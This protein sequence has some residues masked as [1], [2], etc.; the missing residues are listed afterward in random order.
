MEEKMGM[1]WVN[2]GQASA[3]KHFEMVVIMDK[4]SLAEM[5]HTGDDIIGDRA[6]VCTC[7]H[8][9]THRA[10]GSGSREERGMDLTVWIKNVSAVG[11]G[12]GVGMLELTLKI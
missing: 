10:G 6:D 8:P 2:S 3:R 1:T 7:A 5:A 11:V 9:H 4:A 12:V